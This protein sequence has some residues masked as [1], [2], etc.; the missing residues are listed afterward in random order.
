MRGQDDLFGFAQ[1]MV[2]RQRLLL[3]NVQRRPADLPRFQRLQQHRLRNQPS[4]G[5]VH[6]LHPFAAQ[7]DLFL[8]ENPLGLIRHRKVQRQKIAMREQI[9][10]P[11]DQLHLEAAR[12]GQREI[13]VISHHPHAKGNRPPGHLPADPSHAQDPQSLSIQLG[14]LKTFPVPHSSCHRGMG[15][16]QMPRQTQEESEG[17]FRRAHR[18][19]RRCVHDDHPTFCGRIHIH[20]VHPDPGPADRPNRRAS[21]QDGLTDLGLTPDH[22]SVTSL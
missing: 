1:R 6:D 12:L 11:V 17:L 5:A 2:R 19:A 16:W 8:T 20:V 3:K 15:L 4:P 7:F 22:E 10:N 21:L 18:V 14:T 13:R 9:L